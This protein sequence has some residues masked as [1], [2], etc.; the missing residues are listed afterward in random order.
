M[1]RN[2]DSFEKNEL[3]GSSWRRKAFAYKFG[4][5]GAKALR[6][7]VWPIAETFKRRPSGISRERAIEKLIALMD[8]AARTHDGTKLRLLA[9]AVEA[10][11]YCSAHDPLRATLLSL[12]APEPLYKGMACSASMA[13][14]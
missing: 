2:K 9:Y 5:A 4:K 8:E 11:K 1:S 3:D 12:K 10:R 14:K 7:G 13:P 6:A